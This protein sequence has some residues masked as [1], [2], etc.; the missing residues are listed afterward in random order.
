MIA[1][2]SAP[3]NLG[4]RPPE[5]GGVPGTAKA[6]EALRA[7]GLYRR[8]AEEVG[9]IDA[10]LV[11][12]GRYVD[13][14][15]RRPAGRIRNQDAILDHTA[16]LASRIDDLVGEGHAPLV[17]GGDCSILLGPA[18]A[19]AGTGAGLV[20]LDGHTDFRHV[21]SAGPVASLG[22]ED[23][24]AVVGLHLPAISD[25]D[26]RGPYVAPDRAAHLG[27]RDDDGNAAE[28]AGVLGAVVPASRAMRL[29][30]GEA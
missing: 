11:L 3:S 25:I 15:D 28:A 7:A 1:I 20:H 5:P 22:G 24:A 9:A 6:P 14:D 12:A 4:L 8:L 27:C 26:G 29:D 18:L 21:G 19:L 23:L 2:L 10:G 30:P 16:R 17:L 13:D